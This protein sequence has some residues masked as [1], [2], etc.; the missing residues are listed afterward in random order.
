M[1]TASSFAAA[2][3]TS[4]LSVTMRLSVV[5]LM[6]RAL[7]RS[8]V[9]YCDLIFAVIPESECAQAAVDAANTQAAATVASLFITHP[10]C[11]S[12]GGSEQWKEHHLC[13]HCGVRLGVILPGSD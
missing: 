5:T 6:S 7:T 11:S 1:R 4:P 8:S 9:A 12:V 10:P 13:R 3:C 2:D